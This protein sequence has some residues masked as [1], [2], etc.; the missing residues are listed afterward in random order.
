MNIKK[1]SRVA[2]RATQKMHKCEIQSERKLLNTTKPNIKVVVRWIEVA[3]EAGGYTQV[4]AVVA[5][6]RTP[7]QN[8]PIP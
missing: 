8:S 1:I 3:A 7:T 5:V 6:P 2:L 4:K